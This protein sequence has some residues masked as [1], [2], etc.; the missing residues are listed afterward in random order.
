MAT[1]EKTVILHLEEEQ[2][3]HMNQVKSSPRGEVLREPAG[4]DEAG[5]MS[6]W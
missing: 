2:R 5:N 4:A 3:T 6:R 1:A